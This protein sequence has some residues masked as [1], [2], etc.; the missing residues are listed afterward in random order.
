MGTIAAQFADYT[1]L[2]DDETY[3]EDPAS[4]RKAVR[5]GLEA[6]KGS[7]RE[8]GDRKEAIAAAFTE[9]KPGDVVVLTGIGHQDSRNMGG[10]LMAWDEREIARQVLLELGLSKSPQ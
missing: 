3:T 4:I 1:V 6:A 5:D 10:E 8:I 2:T 7:Y 9:A